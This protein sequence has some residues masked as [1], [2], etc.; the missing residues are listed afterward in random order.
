MTNL[1]KALKST[2]NVELDP[3]D[4]VTF[5]HNYCENTMVDVV[6][7]DTLTGCKCVFELF[8]TT[9]GCFLY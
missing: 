5:E 1:E 2:H 4:C 7:T 3:T 6:V 8:D 9:T